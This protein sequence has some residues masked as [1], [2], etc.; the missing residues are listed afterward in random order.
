VRSVSAGESFLA[1]FGSRDQARMDEFY[2]PD[3]VMYTPLTGPLRG[4]D[5]IW[6]YFSDVHRGFPG[7][8][9]ALHD[10]F[11]STDG[12]RS[13][14]RVNLGWRNSG[15][16]RGKPATGKSG[17]MPETHVF[18]F[19][20]GQV[21]EQISGISGFQMPSLFLA[22]WGMS[23]P[24]DVADP[25]PEIC[26]AAPGDA[27]VAG[28]GVSLARRFADAFG[29]KDLDVL[30]DIYAQDVALY[31][32]LAWPASG[33][34]AVTAFAM[35]FHAANPGLR[36]ALH[37]EFYSPDGTR[38]CWRIRLHYHNTAPF[39]GQPPTDEAGVMTETHVVRLAGGRIVEHVV[40]DNAFHMPHQ[41]LVTWK[42]PFPE[43]T[44]DPAPEIASVTAPTAG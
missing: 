44:P 21:A 25:A 7:L 34:E 18:L 23:F 43:S 2:A 22:D 36:I 15:S 6:D 42:M 10:E 5:Q 40:G 38:A 8:R 1:S 35:E 29:R 19:K 4:R 13:C 32:P 20:D 41:E 3:A 17:D 12:T 14:I 37:D 28:P 9:V 39:Y 26:S 16:F 24:R 33:R 11:G 30:S 27:P 31:T